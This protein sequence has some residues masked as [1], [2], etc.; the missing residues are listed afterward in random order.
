MYSILCWHAYDKDYCWP[1]YSKLAER[2]NCSINSIK[3]YFRELV[4]AKLVLVQKESYRSS[5]YF[6]LKPSEEMGNDSR[7]EHCAENLVSPQDANLSNFDGNPPKFG[8]NPSNVG[9]LKNP[10]KQIQETPPS[11][12]LPQCNIESPE[13]EKAMGV[14]DSFSDF[15]RVYAA[16][17]RKE[18]KGLAR[19]AW[20]NLARSNS[21][22]AP[23][24]ILEA[25]ERFKGTTNWQRENGR[26]IPQLSNFLKGE[27][28]NDP[29]SEAE[30]IEQQ[31]KQQAALANAR[32]QEMIERKKM[33]YEA[34]R[35]ELSPL[36]DEFAA[37][38]KGTFHRPLVFG[39]WLALHDRGVAPLASDVPKDNELDI[40][41]F[42]KWFSNQRRYEPENH[43]P[44]ENRAA[45]KPK[46]VS[47]AQTQN[48]RKQADG[49]VSS[50]GEL[51]KSLLSKIR[52]GKLPDNAN[53]NPAGNPLEVNEFF[54]NIAK[55]NRELAI[56][57]TAEI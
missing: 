45:P 30:V 49:R 41:Q 53:E 27:R 15:E 1:S 35:L 38:F 46:F 2:M 24:V 50:S 56:N 33:E 37:K 17:P 23:S 7:R 4:K 6:L 10:N 26:F 44:A 13:K 39:H 16:Y 25:I 32:C 5:K 8:E 51:I 40:S 34:K 28:W 20:R 43:S 19:A 55:M 14:G 3:N 42:L 54:C 48:P 36:F 18:A 21:L 57:G 47:P 9:Y 11:T 52:A 22:P 31:Q 12:N 29:L